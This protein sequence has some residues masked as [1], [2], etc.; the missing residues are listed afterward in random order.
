[1]NLTRFYRISAVVIVAQLL[2]AAWGF[3]N[4]GLTADA[5]IHWGP[6]GEI[7]GYAPAWIAFL[8]TPVLTAGVVG[9]MALVP[10]IEPRRENLRRSA[11]AYRTTA[12]ALAL[13]FGVVQ[14]GIVV[15]GVT[16][17]FPMATVLGFGIGVLFAVM[18]NVMTT[19]RPNFMFGVRTPWTLASDLSWDRTHR[20]IGRL[21][22]ALGI[23]LVVLS[24]LG[25]LE[26]VIGVMLAGILGVLVLAF[27]YSYRVWRE[28]PDKRPSGGAP[29]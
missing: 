13:F 20:L 29:A 21:F 26:L 7:D 25:R 15:A 11:D 3:A 27:W 10:R 16:G 14:V 17:S 9:L 18:G 22:V 12:I 1:M 28:D 8:M 19:V 23:T 24:L 5:P 6:S 4:V 2:V